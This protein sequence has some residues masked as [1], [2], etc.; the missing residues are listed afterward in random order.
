MQTSNYGCHCGYIY[1]AVNQ[2]DDDNQW[3]PEKL[4]GSHETKWI[5]IHQVWEYVCLELSLQCLPKKLVVGDLKKKTAGRSPL[6]V[7]MF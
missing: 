3:N 2:S 5:R 1:V 6:A 4:H 7:R